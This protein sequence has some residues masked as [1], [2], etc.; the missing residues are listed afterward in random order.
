MADYSDEDFKK[1]QE[2]KRLI[3]EKLRANNNS[4]EFVVDPPGALEPVDDRRRRGRRRTR[5][6][7]GRRAG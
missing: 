6:T 3:Q 1:G 5:P 4:V 2:Q 7:P